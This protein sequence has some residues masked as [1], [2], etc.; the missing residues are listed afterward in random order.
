MT[1]SI[2]PPLTVGEEDCNEMT[3]N[4]GQLSDGDVRKF[5]KHTR[6]DID[7]G[8]PVE[9]V[10]NGR[11]SNEKV[12]ASSMQSATF[13]G[14]NA[15]KRVPSQTLNRSPKPVSILPPKPIKPAG[16]AEEPSTKT[17][18]KAEKS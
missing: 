5:K 3:R 10:L 2:I 9:S 11:F 16:R 13:S 18:I 1:A 15:L 7:L 17:E 6:V 14:S 8:K 4:C 12:K